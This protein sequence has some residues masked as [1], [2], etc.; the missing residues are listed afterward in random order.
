MEDVYDNKPILYK[1]LIIHPHQK[2]KNKNKFKNC[3]ETTRYLLNH[4]VQ[5][6]KTYF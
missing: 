2:I 5:K 1:P 3:T 4:F 6:Y